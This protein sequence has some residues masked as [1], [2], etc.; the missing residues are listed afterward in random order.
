VDAKDRAGDPGRLVPG[1]VRVDD[2][3]RRL[4][5]VAEP[6]AKRLAGRHLAEAQHEVG[7]E[8]R[9]SSSS[10][11][12]VR[13]DD[14]VEF[15][16]AQPELRGRL[17]EDRHSRRLGKGRDRGGRSRQHPPGDDQAPLARPD[18]LGER[19]DERRRRR[20]RGR[21]GD[22]RQRPVEVAPLECER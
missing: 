7:L 22:G 21:R 14:E 13:R 4:L 5:E 20:G 10:E 18:A 12:L 1:A 3:L 8:L 11:R 17:G 6:L 16:R 2:K 19:L 9:P 15:V